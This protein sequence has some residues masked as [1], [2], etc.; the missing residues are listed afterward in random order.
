MHLLAH[1]SG[2]PTGFFSS[3]TR[4]TVFLVVLTLA[5]VVLTVALLGQAYYYR[6]RGSPR[7]VI[8]YRMSR[9]TPVIAS[10]PLRDAAGE[11]TVMFRDE[12]VMKPHT[13]ALTVESRARRDISDDDFYRGRPLVFDL[14]APV[15]TVL[16]SDPERTTVPADS[17]AIDGNSLRL[18]PCLIHPGPVLSIEVLTD[19]RPAVRCDGDGNPMKDIA[20]RGGAEQDRR[21]RTRRYVLIAGGIAIL[22]GLFLGLTE[23][24]ATNLIDTVIGVSLLLVVAAPSL[25]FF[26]PVEPNRDEVER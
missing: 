4:L 15:V 12:R 24:L 8:V 14:R 1:G 22:F 11:V 5:L 3:T 18:G 17:I 21:T 19:G 10:R 13:A 6:R 25:P 7:P 16:Y 9:P 20:V 26:L 2:H 23:V